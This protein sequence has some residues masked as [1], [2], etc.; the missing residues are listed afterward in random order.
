MYHLAHPN[1]YASTMHPSAVPYTHLFY[2]FFYLLLS[3]IIGL[4]SALLSAISY[5]DIFLYVIFPVYSYV[6][7]PACSYVDYY[8]PST[9]ASREAHL[10]DLLRSSELRQAIS[11]DENAQMR[12]DFARRSAGLKAS[13]EADAL[14]MRQDFQERDAKRAEELEKEKAAQ[15][16]ATDA[17]ISGVVRP[18]VVFATRKPR[19]LMLP[20]LSTDVELER[21]DVP[22]APRCQEGDGPHGA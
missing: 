15:E 1:Q 16:Q 6:I 21:Q 14:Q 2:S 22:R 17:W 3:F 4:S 9:V 19:S 20:L 5:Q 13:Y 8:L 18:F 12:E 10:R 11:R 7:L